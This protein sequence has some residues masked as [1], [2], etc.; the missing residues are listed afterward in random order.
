VFYSAV[1][2]FSDRKVIL[3]GDHGKTMFAAYGLAAEYFSVCRIL[4]S[5]NCATRETLSS[6]NQFL[7]FCRPFRP[8]KCLR[9]PVALFYMANNYTMKC[10]P[11]PLICIMNYRT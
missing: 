1:T 6:R 5:A 9:G 2:E 8:W 11:Y 4:S 10:L 3:G 7:I